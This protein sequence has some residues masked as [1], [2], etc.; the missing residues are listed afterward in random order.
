MPANRTGRPEVTRPHKSAGHSAAAAG[1]DH[2]APRAPGCAGHCQQAAVR[3]VEN[4]MHG[5]RLASLA[6]D[7]GSVC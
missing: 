7:A 3:Q 6:L 5:S 2:N 1:H 4:S